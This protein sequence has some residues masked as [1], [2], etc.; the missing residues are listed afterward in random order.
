MTLRCACVLE[1]YS[2]S[3]SF[4]ALKTYLFLFCGLSIHVYLYTGS[5]S[6]LWLLLFVM[7]IKPN[8]NCQVMFLAIIL[9]QEFVCVLYINLSVWNLVSVHYISHSTDQPLS[10]LYESITSLCTN[11]LCEVLLSS[12]AI[13]PTRLTQGC[14]H[15]VQSLPGCTNQRWT[16]VLSVG[17]SA[18]VN[19]VCIRGCEIVT[20]PIP[21][22]IIITVCCL[23]LGYLATAHICSHSW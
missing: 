2:W 22:L 6:Y 17:A 12:A 8:Q 3:F 20:A 21:F 18:D 11:C 4:Q 16:S 10:D 1:L 23:S 9:F 5:C 15:S 13:A 7:K 19:Q 14:W